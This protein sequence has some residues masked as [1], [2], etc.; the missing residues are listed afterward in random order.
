MRQQVSSAGPP[1][2][3][4]VCSRWREKYQ[5]TPRKVFRLQADAEVPEEGIR[6]DI[7][8]LFFRLI[9]LINDDSV[10]VPRC[11]SATVPKVPKF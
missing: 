10:S 7:G 11:N 3:G 2:S 1:S 8:K 6:G 5:N 9:Q 4:L